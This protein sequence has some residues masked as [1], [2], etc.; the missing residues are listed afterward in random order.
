MPMLA[1]IRPWQWATGCLS[2]LQAAS[3]GNAK[4]SLFWHRV[5]FIADHTRRIPVNSAIFLSQSAT[6]VPLRAAQ[7]TTPAANIYVPV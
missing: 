3:I 1:G 5:P 6:H 2:E 4:V 7:L